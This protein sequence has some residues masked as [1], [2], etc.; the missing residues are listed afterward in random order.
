[1]ESYLTH[2]HYDLVTPDGKITAIDSIQENRL[3]VNVLIEQIS[4]KFKGFEIDTHLVHFNLK[5]TL[6]QLGINTYHTEIH[7]DKVKQ[8]AEIE[9]YLQALDPLSKAMLP[10]LKTGA[11][12][13]KLFAA[14]DRR[15]VRNPDYLLRMFGR[16]DRMGRSLLFFGK[17]YGSDDFVLE[18]I[19]NRTLAFIALKDGVIAYKESMNDFL[20]TLEKTLHFTHFKTRDLIALHQKWMKHQPKVLKDA[21]TLL[22]KTAPLHIR[23]VFA[24]VVENQLPKGFHHTSAN[25]LQPDTFASGDIYEFFGASNQEID[26]IPLE[27]YTLEPHREHVFFEDR[28]QLQA[29]I[30]DN[31]TLFKAFAKGPSPSN[32]PAAV[33]IVK[34][35]QLQNLKMKDWILRDLHKHEF[36]GISH[37]SRQAAV[38][39]RYIEKQPTFPFLKAIEEELITSQ[40]ILLTRY[41]PSPLMKRFFLS[42]FVQRCLKRIYFEKPS[43]TFG[44]YFSF[45]DRAFLVDLAKFGI[46]VYWVDHSTKKILQYVLRPEKD[47]G[48]FVPFDL[49]EHFRKSTMFGVYG[50]NLQ[51][52]PYEQEL[53]SLMQGIL[54][55][56][57]FV[58]HPL[59]SSETPIALVTGGG[60]GVMELGNQVAKEL[61][62]LSCANIADFQGE[63]HHIV[64]EQKINPY[65]D[66]K[67]TY[68]LD[69][70]VERQAEFHLDFPI[71]LQGGIGM[72]FEYTLEEVRRKTGASAATPSILFGPV[73]YW[74]D[75]VGTRFQ[76]NLMSGTIKGSEWVSNCFYCVQ[77]AKQA[78][79][80]YQKYFE[81]KLA[82]GKDGPVYQ[83]GFHI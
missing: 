77:T 37:P 24:K 45:E 72:D 14:D 65:I 25:V 38:V 57:E 30:E 48:M 56:R 71:F 78:L 36:P 44:E 66:A 80:V 41:F 31:T 73:D 28:D 18:K 4:A 34:G 50:S 55:L 16:S 3:K 17:S 20:P 74:T 7:L 13:G 6:A 83:Q 52:G 76:R 70:L 49:V 21:Q 42:S 68:R 82:I 54:N 33:F 15:I 11:Y 26:S 62:I 9:L 12:I 75:K 19:E 81:N 2:S 53:K 63:K 5:S 1:M 59:L 79:E 61:G 27:F 67:M 58:N 39:E 64:H 47:T 60:P 51:K 23:T 40:G 29:A 32:T 35:D 46:P 69:H 43:Y 8:R 22:V 10:L